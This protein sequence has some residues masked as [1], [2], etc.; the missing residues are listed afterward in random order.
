MSTSLLFRFVARRTVKLKPA[1]GR[2]RFW[3]GVAVGLG[4]QLVVLLLSY[5]R[6]TTWWQVLSVAAAALAVFYGLRAI[7]RLL[8]PEEE[9]LLQRLISRQWRAGKL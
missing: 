2:A 9:Q 8:S 7:F 6:L 5:G 4:G 3:A 1:P